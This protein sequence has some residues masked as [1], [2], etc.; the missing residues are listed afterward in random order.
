M[1]LDIKIFEVRI[2]AYKKIEGFFF[3]E[4]FKIRGYCNGNSLIILLKDELKGLIVKKKFN[5]RC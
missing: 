4:N 5:K 1:K 3:V 2:A